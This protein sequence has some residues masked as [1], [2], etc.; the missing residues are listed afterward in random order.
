M[1]QLAKDN[2]VLL[3][4]VGFLVCVCLCFNMTS[5]LT[6][7]ANAAAGADETFASMANAA[8]AYFGEC[9]SAAGNNDNFHFQDLTDLSAYNMSSGVNFG[10]Y[11]G[12]LG[13]LGDGKVAGVSDTSG[14]NATLYNADS[15]TTTRIGHLFSSRSFSGSGTADS[16]AA[17]GGAYMTT[18]TPFTMYVFYGHALSR[19]G[20]DE[21]GLNASGG[22]P[23]RMIVGTL[24]MALYIASLGV[25]TFF[26]L[27]ITILIH[28]NP[29]RLFLDVD[30]G[31]TSGQIMQTEAMTS[32]TARGDVVN[33]IVN[34]VSTVQGYTRSFYDM[35]QNM[36][37]L[38]LMPLFLGFALFNWLIINKGGN[39]WKSTKGFIIR[40]T[41][42]ILGVPMMFA[43]YDAAL[44]TM[45]GTLTI[46]NNFGTEIVASTFCDFESWVTVSNLTLPNGMKID[47]N[48]Y[49]RNISPATQAR[50]R[51][52]CY[53]INRFS[54]SI[55]N[56]SSR[57]TGASVDAATNSSKIAVSDTTMLNNLGNESANAQTL[58]NT[59]DVLTRYSTGEYF[60]AGRYASYC[61]TF[62]S[63]QNGDDA[64][65]YRI[66]TAS[67][68]T[69]ADFDW[70]RAS[71]DSG[72]NYG[73]VDGANDIVLTPS[74]VTAMTKGRFTFS[75]WPDGGN[76]SSS[77]SRVR[78]PWYSDG[79]LK[80]HY[81]SLEAFS[82]RGTGSFS[83]NVTRGGIANYGLSMIAMYNYLDS[84]FTDT[85]VY[86]QSS[87][88][89]TVSDTDKWY[90]Y[91]VTTVGTGLMKIFY[92]LDAVALMGCL[93]VVGYGY[94]L[95]LLFA[96]LKAMFQMI[97]KVFKG[98]FGSMEG[99]AASVIMMFALICN[100]IFT[101]L[102]YTLA[103][104]IIK[105]IYRIVEVPL[106]LLFDN[107]PFFNGVA[108][109][110]MPVVGLAS[111]YVVVMVT[112]TLLRWRKAVVQSTTEACTS[113][114]NKFLGTHQGTPDLNS[115]ADGLG[116]KLLGAAGVAGGLAMA[117][118]AG[119]LSGHSLAA[120]EG[121]K[122]AD[123][124]GWSEMRNR[125]SDA[126][127]GVQEGF[128]T[129]GASGAVEA[130]GL[131][132]T[133]SAANDV[134]TQSGNGTTE[135]DMANGKFGVSSGSENPAS[136]NRD[137][138]KRAFANGS[139]VSANGSA[140]NADGKAYADMD[141]EELAQAYEN[142]ELVASQEGTEGSYAGIASRA[143]EEAEA[144]RIAGY[145]NGASAG[146]K[147]VGGSSGAG[148]NIGS[149]SDAYGAGAL[150]PSGKEMPEGSKDFADMSEAELTQ[151]YQDGYLVASDSGAEAV[152]SSIASG[153]KNGGSVAGKTYDQIAGEY[154]DAEKGTYLD[155][156]SE[157]MTVQGK[158]S[159]ITV[160]PGESTVSMAGGSGSGA[161]A[162]SLAMPQNEYINANAVNDGGKQVITGS[163]GTEYIVKNAGSNLV[164][165][166][167]GSQ[168]LVM[169]NQGEVHA[170][171]AGTKYVSA[172]GGATVGV[173][174]AGG[175]F[176]TVAG[177][178]AQGTV[179]K[180]NGGTPF[181]VDNKNQS[182]RMTGGTAVVSSDGTQY[183]M[184]KNND[185][186][187]IAPEGSSYRGNMGGGGT[188]VINESGDA[189][190][191]SKNRDVYRVDSKNPSQVVDDGGRHYRLDKNGD[192]YT[193]NQNSEYVTKNNVRYTISDSGEAIQ[194]TS[195][196]RPTGA[197]NG[198]AGGARMGS[199]NMW[200][201]GK[202]FGGTQS[203][204]KK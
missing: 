24:M 168:E 193:V 148:Q 204:N 197:G 56:L 119:S 27:V 81:I 44:Q 161:A 170:K 90:H 144:E 128:E 166:M 196:S 137:E 185:A 147:A 202:T 104:D 203:P 78:N 159:N 76:Y 109:I 87:G 43:C 65:T 41:F 53:D 154:V 181:V 49:E 12:F 165:T 29:F 72:H 1:R 40:M 145:S 36:S 19:C 143:L 117:S 66:L 99:I 63:S 108:S 52:Y 61:K 94:A 103:T 82:Y 149:M 200:Q 91:S 2:K 174:D 89:S 124:T 194:V 45:K 153:K 51:D 114:V 106:A 26:E 64:K 16:A 133:S 59:L 84:Q 192:V 20:F 68:S 142:G 152:V 198:A 21:V 35:L 14:S 69:P 105:A 48:I 96:N 57:A 22:T 184:S 122:L 3:M 101:I 50:L 58:Q 77:G 37:L 11:G 118:N 135:T 88:V 160:E 113:L 70:K 71:S 171:V 18:M 47:Y 139:L 46:D 176:L 146:T 120:G 28:A 55:G 33:A 32:T 93:S 162:G 186:Y 130:L 67:S 136:I 10:R 179:Y 125:L 177:N 4:L 13:Y 107:I 86:V 189:Y 17:A 132:G 169:D 164:T 111:L 30:L 167:D 23:T 187:R 25:G 173:V 6:P 79:S 75:Y 54:G 42:L 195:N 5:M 85:G 110:I 157:N 175:N 182:Y 74:Q 178:S 112:R 97:P 191:I 134:L 116:G 7:K 150:V 15:L 127:E 141:G 190:V 199:S 8:A 9:T 140:T 151:A 60:Q 126:V 138:M 98:M 95:A 73:Q 158:G 188:H 62:M 123:N 155:S 115:P 180:D 38:V 39:F 100:V 183:I 131:G 92:I 156:A 172:D 129:N 83:R 163:N 80:C 201:P 31:V 102:L 34:G 121:S